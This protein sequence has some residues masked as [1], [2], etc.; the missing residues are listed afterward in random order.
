M[1]IPRASVLVALTSSPIEV[2]ANVSRSR[3]EKRMSASSTACSCSCASRRPLCAARDEAVDAVVEV[4]HQFLPPAAHALAVTVRAG[5]EEATQMLVGVISHVSRVA[6][7]ARLLTR[8]SIVEANRRRRGSGRET[9]RSRAPAPRSACCRPPTARRTTGS[10][11]SRGPAAP[12]LEVHD[13]RGEPHARVADGRR[14]AQERLLGLRPPRR[15]RHGL[16]DQFV[17]V[18]LEVGERGRDREEA[19]GPGAFAQQP[20]APRVE[21][22]EAVADGRAVGRRVH[23][24]RSPPTARI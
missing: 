21:R 24:F 7:P 18:D 14:P 4:D 23:D 8:S 22:D 15:P 6:R 11:R 20:R 17:L 10:R 2:P 3:V 5:G 12:E 13:P 16:H 19:R 1:Q 9:S